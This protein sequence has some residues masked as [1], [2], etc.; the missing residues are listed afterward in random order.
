[1]QLDNA[2][3]D[4]QSYPKAV[5]FACESC[6]DSVKGLED[7]RKVLRWDCH[8]VVAYADLDQFLIL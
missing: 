7:L 3:A 5:H 6:V 2:L 4:G 8:A 1:M